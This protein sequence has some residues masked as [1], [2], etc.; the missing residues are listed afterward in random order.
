MMS[1][2]L[3]ESYFVWLYSQVADRRLRNPSRT[4]WGLLRELHRKEFV[5]LIPNDDNRIE[6]GRALRYEF[7]EECGIRDVPRDW[8]RLGCSMLELLIGLS[9][10]LADMA[11]GEPSGW[12][13]RLIENLD[14]EEYNDNR[15]P[16]DG[17]INRKLDT[18]IWRTYRRN[19]NG[20]LFPLNRTRND[21]RWVEIWYQ[22]NEYLQQA[23]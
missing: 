13:W 7:M 17:Y 2:P 5:W 14:L 10:R 9:R 21:Q 16:Q 20:G 11:D 15:L 12:F 4:Y 1:E 19:G 23:S 3:D 8:M 6:D 22:L 18:V